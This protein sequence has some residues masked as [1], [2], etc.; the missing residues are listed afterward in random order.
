MPKKFT[1][2]NV[3]SIMQ[4]EGYVLL[5]EYQGY[6]KPLI[7]KC[8]RGHEYQTTLSSWRSGVRCP[9]CTGRKKWCYDEVKAAFEK[10]G[11]QLL[12]KGYKNNKQRLYFICPN[13]HRGYILWIN[14]LK[15]HRCFMC[16]RIKASIKQRKSF[17]YIKKAFSEEGYE[18]L[19][20]GYVN[21]NTKLKFKCPNGH[22][23]YTTWREWASGKRCA[24]CAGNA[25]PSYEIVKEA[26]VCE[27][28]ELLSERYINSYAKLKCK[29]PYGHVIYISWDKW[30]HGRRCSVCAAIKRFGSG[31]PMWRGGKSFE[32]YCSLWKD[33]DF[34][35]YIKWRDGYICNNAGCTKNTDLVI[36]HVD[37]N[38]K[39]CELSNLITLCRAC[40]SR[41]NKNRVWYETWFKRL[42]SRKFGYKYE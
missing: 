23:Y 31:N 42:L 22:I 19:S 4:L 20:S 18:L 15:G 35:E 7:V 1:T 36:H 9:L 3:Q 21:R 40:N 27:G 26:F 13:G 6:Y 12:N 41:V 14:W 24:V 30:K 25:K 16:G 17:D 10:E 37:Y 28:Y 33:R 5:S 34:K 2:Y 8:S 39:N 29:C 38:K 32:R 11:Y